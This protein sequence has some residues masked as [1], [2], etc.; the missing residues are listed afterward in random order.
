MPS[1]IAV[2]VPGALLCLTTGVPPATGYKPKVVK[3]GPTPAPI[4]ALASPI[5]IPNTLP[6]FA[7]VT[8]PGSGLRVPK[9]RPPGETAISF[10][11]CEL[12]FRVLASASFAPVN[13]LAYC[14]S[15]VPLRVA[16]TKKVTS[17]R[18]N[19]TAFGSAVGSV[20]GTAGDIAAPSPPNARM[21]G[22]AVVVGR[23]GLP[24]SNRSS[25]IRRTD[26]SG[27]NRTL[28][29]VL[30]PT[31]VYASSELSE[32]ARLETATT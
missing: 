12:L 11:N 13:A 5:S 4:A 24:V 16:A 31:T 9:A 20:F 2:V 7:S 3:P 27:S 29:V 8:K 32:M 17:D 19:G 30:P 28:V 23:P 1:P 22:P 14:I 18:L 25:E 26:S 10:T 6:L 21:T 15:G